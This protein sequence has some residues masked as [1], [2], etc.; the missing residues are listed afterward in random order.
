[1]TDALDLL[2]VKEFDGGPLF[3]SQ[4]D[5]VQQLL[6]TPPYFVKSED[7][8]EHQKALSRLKA[9]LSQ[10]LSTS[11]TR[12]ITEDFLVALKILL[13]KRIKNEKLRDQTF[14]SIIEDLR[15]KNVPGTRAEFKQPLRNTIYADVAAGSFIVI[16][17]ATPINTEPPYKTNDFSVRQLFIEDLLFN[18]TTKDAPAKKYHF[19][20]PLET[21]C[22]MFWITFEMMLLT[23]LEYLIDSEDLIDLLYE[24]FVIKTET[25][26][27]AATYYKYK[28]HIRDGNAGLLEETK[29]ALKQSLANNVIEL[30][31][32]NRL[33]VASHT[34]EP[35]FSVPLLAINV[36]EM[37][38]GKLYYLVRDEQNRINI[39]RTGKENLMLWTLFTWNKIKASKNIKDVFCPAHFRK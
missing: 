20:F 10:L 15:Q 4:M 13:F 3:R 21:Y 2:F 32:R 25:H 35:I 27:L 7:P 9:Y 17:S 29:L 22:D 34:P 33:V 31:N 38:A 16:I 26:T 28:N 6:A 19:Y 23:Y 24:K 8:A 14:E 37:G 36:N 11:A 12:S 1:M 30:L 39:I 5:L 18:L